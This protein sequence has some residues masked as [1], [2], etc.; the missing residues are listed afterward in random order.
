[1][2]KEQIQSNRLAIGW[3]IRNKRLSLKLSQEKLGDKLKVR[4]HTISKIERGEWAI[5]ID[6]LYKICEALDLTIQLKDK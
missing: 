5:S 6:Y 2:N 1:M 4:P 3:A